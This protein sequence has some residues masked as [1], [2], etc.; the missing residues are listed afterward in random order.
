[1]H[2]FPVSLHRVFFTWGVLAIF[3]LFAPFL[4]RAVDQNGN[5]M[6]DVWEAAYGWDRIP[7]ADDDGDGQSNLE[8]SGAGTD[9]SNPRS[10]HRIQSLSIEGDSVHLEWPTMAGKRYQVQVS[11]S[12]DEATWHDVGSV[13]PGD[14]A[15]IEVDFPLSTTFTGDGALL[16]VWRGLEDEAG[17]N[18]DIVKGY[19][20][21][22][23]PP[24]TEESTL[25][26]LDTPVD[27]DDHYSQ[28]VRGWLIPPTTGDYLFWI[29]SDDRGELRL[30]PSADPAEAVPIANVPYFTGHLVWNKYPE[31]QESDA[32]TL[33]ANTP[34]YFEAFMTEWDGGD[35]LSIAW[36][37]P[38]FA[39]ELI[40]DAQMA[41][42]PESLAELGRTALFFRVIAG[43]TDSDGD[44]VWDYEEKLAEL[45]PNNPSTTPR[46]ADR[47]MLL[48]ILSAENVVTVGTPEDRAYETGATCAQFVIRRSGGME[49]LTIGYSI[50]G[51]AIAGT[52]Y[53]ALPGTVTMGPS[54]KSV[55]ID[56]TPQPDFDVEP[57]ETVTLNLNPGTDYHVGNP[58]TA[59]V[60]IDDAPDV[61]Y[62]ATL[63][64]GTAPEERSGGYG[65][66]ALRVAGNKIFGTL[67][68]QFGNLNSQQIGAE[69]FLS[70]T[71]AGGD[72]VLDLPLGQ[73]TAERWEF[74]STPEQSTA[75]I[76]AALEGSQLHLRIASET[77]PLGEISGTFLVSPGWETMPI[78][79]AVPT[80]PETLPGMGVTAEQAARFLTQAT[81]GPTSESI[82]ELQ[83][84]GIDTWLNE[85]FA[86][87][88]TLHL[89]D[90]RQCRARYLFKYGHDGWQSPR[91]ETWWQRALTAD[92]QLRQRMA[93]ALS[94]IFVIS[95]LGV[96][97][98]SHEGVT[99]WYDMLLEN[100]F[101]NY[102]DLLEKVTLSPI[103]GQYLSMVR[104]RKPDPETGSEPDE[105]YAREV[106][107]LFSIGLS[108]LNLDGSLK[109]DSAGMP[110]PTYNQDVIIGFAHVFTGWGYAYTG[111]PPSF[112]WGPQNDM[113][114]MVQYPDYHD[115][116][117]KHLLDGHVVPAGQTG[118]Q[119]LADALDLLANQ[120]NV[121]PF[122][123]K[124][125]I[126]RFVTSNPSPGYVYRAATAF[127]A[128]GGNL[129]ATLRAIL[130][131]FEARSDTMLSNTTFGK[132]REPV[133]RY[134]HLLRAMNAQ[135]PTLEEPP[136][137]GEPTM[138][139][140][141]FFLNMQYSFSHQ[142][143]LRSPSV[144]NFFQPGFLPPGEL[145]EAGLYG[146]EFQIA[147]E[148]TTITEANEALAL[149]HWGRWTS[150]SDA[151]GNGAGNI[152]PDLADELA[153]LQNPDA[154]LQENLESLLDHLNLKLLSGQMSPMLRQ[155][156]L[157]GWAALPAWYDM[158]GDRPAGRVKL[159]TYVIYTSP[160]YA[161]Q[162]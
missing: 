48:G 156:I 102:R 47:E 3:L 81:F 101:G 144:F 130:T 45:D 58:A 84:K 33:H 136:A 41:T 13:L 27:S 57:A 85:Q 155:A 146:P 9:P 16:S 31:Y 28:W 80:P 120:P 25:A 154:T 149:I 32:V 53:D 35:A 30:S 118:E 61:L 161:V 69:I 152:Y 7:S 51:T 4:A 2:P 18:L 12:L 141:W 26:I 121:A 6:S 133:I 10:V 79:P 100:A 22:G 147:T 107:Q 59:T 24:P 66:A 148:S 5:G 142:A 56:V 42:T 138:P 19:A 71:G 137:E 131:D 110:I 83:T 159:A 134:A 11:A 127:N 129:G 64:G 92:D 111:D 15:T 114:P 73:I 139:E 94:E 93:F 49:P 97:D 128:S 140:G 65:Y 153:I 103:M 76:L 90:M 124:Q 68:L 44:G 34:Y 105:N 55:T 157:D 43:D 1:M 75:Q 126:Q 62:V 116:G 40:S 89:P 132:L 78:P 117:E 95:E 23:T 52:D 125:L 54:Q 123:A 74:E 39:R 60:T 106:M 99:N 86:M 108:Q 91:H 145:S 98:D 88:P 119:D 160:E 72:V 122:L 63:R 50:S 87:A 14:G 21:T 37:G 143:P 8:E 113:D 38:G 150:E 115:T 46:V 36:S 162:K 77:F 104:N 96:L 67:S 135:P 112:L 29:A 109:I 17:W 158:S 151:T 20:A 70:P 82:A